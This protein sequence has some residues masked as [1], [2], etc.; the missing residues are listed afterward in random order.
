MEIRCPSCGSGFVVEIH[1]DNEMFCCPDCD[2]SFIVH[3]NKSFPAAKAVENTPN[4]LKVV[5]P[6]CRQHYDINPD[7]FN[8]PFGCQ[9]CG[10]SFI[11]PAPRPARPAP[12]PQPP[13]APR[14]Q[15]QQQE[16]KT[17]VMDRQFSSAPRNVRDITDEVKAAAK[18]P[19]TP[20]KK[21]PV[22]SKIKS[23]P[24]QILL[25]F[26]NF[27]IMIISLILKWL[28]LL[29]AISGVIWGIVMTIQGISDNS[30]VDVLGG[31]LIML[32]SPFITHMMF[33]LLMLAFA[34][35]DVLKEIRDKE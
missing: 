30:F 4:G 21:A 5:C 32:F 29:T 31:V 27:K 15:P 1:N 22:N 7:F 33:E 34:I 20:A 25:D 13:P 10:K 19:A 8:S 18:E 28:W 35:L 3:G 16:R 23:K 17:A 12:P 11:V 24:L 2:K 6:G 9:V 26:L 14:P